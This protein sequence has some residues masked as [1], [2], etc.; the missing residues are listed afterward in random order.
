MKRLPT[1]VSPGTN[2]SVSRDELV[3]LQG[4]TRQ[5]SRHGLVQDETGTRPSPVRVLRH[6]PGG[7]GFK[8]VLNR[9]VPECEVK[10][11]FDLHCPSDIPFK[12]DIGIQC[13][14]E[15]P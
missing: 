15:A 10:R 1:T 6:A 3:S 4:R 14:L 5:V 13:V 2:L 11:N 12:G 9:E 8:L 7:L